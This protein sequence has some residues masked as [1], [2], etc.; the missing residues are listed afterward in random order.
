MTGE[1]RHLV[2]LVSSC[3]CCVLMQVVWTSASRISGFVCTS[4]PGLSVAFGNS[5]WLHRTRRPRYPILENQDLEFK[6][7]GELY[8]KV[9]ESGADAT[10]GSW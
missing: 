9:S 2:A 3:F 4:I 7:I 8:S 10:N 5:I 6:L 1:P